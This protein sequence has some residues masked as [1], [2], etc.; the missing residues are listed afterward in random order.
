A[1]AFQGAGGALLSPGSLA[2]LQAT[3]RSE[4]RSA[5]VG[6]WS[7]LGGLATALG[8]FAG[9]YLIEAVSWRLIFLL[10]VPLAAAVLWLAMR[11]VPVPR[12][13]R[14]PSTSPAPPWRPSASAGSPGR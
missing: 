1:R 8:P 11:H 12:G 2:I 13:R 6:A 4:D 10:N 9:G 14:P 5:A 3:F 7:G